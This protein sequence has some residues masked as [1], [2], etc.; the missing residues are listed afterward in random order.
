MGSPRN[1]SLSE[2]I[3][4]IL[5]THSSELSVCIPGVVTDWNKNFG[6]VKVR[7]TILKS[8]GSRR[9]ETSWIPVIFPGVYWDV[10]NGEHGLLVVGDEDWRTWWRTGEEALPESQSGHDLQNAYFVPG[11]QTK[12]DSRTIPSNVRILEKPVA[13]GYVYLGSNTA[14]KFV[15]H[16]DLGSYLNAFLTALDSWGTTNHGDWLTASGAFGSSVSSFIT[17][18]KN[19][20]YL[21]DSVKVED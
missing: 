7:P 20:D 12:P 13:G 11:L 14:N 10:Q 18:L 16:E 1:Q 6:I 17:A 15:V 21:S 9:A 5:D 8:D 19:A 4:E 3:G 2:V